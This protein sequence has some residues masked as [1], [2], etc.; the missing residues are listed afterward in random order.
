GVILVLSSA[1]PWLGVVAPMPAP[2]RIYG[3]K[4][5]DQKVLVQATEKRERAEAGGG[6]KADTGPAGAALDDK[7]QS[8]TLTLPHKADIAADG[9]PYWAPV[10]SRST[11]GEVKLVA[12]PKKTPYVYQ[13]VAFENPAPYPLMAGRVHTWRNGTFVGDTWLEHKGPGAPIEASLGID[14]AFRAEREVIKD[15]SRDPGFLSSTRTLPRELAFTLKSRTRTAATVELREN[16]PV[17]KVDDIKVKLDKEQ[18]TKGYALDSLT[19]LLTWPVKLS[20]NGE[21]EVKLGYRI[22]LPEDWKIN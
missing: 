18:T 22:E 15:S 10:D 1:K 6:A 13:V 20:G 19:G 8:I 3:S 2:L 7:G 12:V 11:R 16:I 21:A 14:E 9:R 5:S 4:G 17:S